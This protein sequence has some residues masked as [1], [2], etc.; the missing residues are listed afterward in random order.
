[1]TSIKRANNFIDPKDFDANKI[2]FSD[3]KSFGTN[4]KTAFII[5]NNDSNLGFKVPKMRMPFG[6]S[7]YVD[8][9]KP[10]KY[11]VDVSFDPDNNDKKMK[12][13]Y[14]ALQN[15]D[16]KILNE[17]KKNSLAWLRKKHITDDVLQSLFNPSI[18]KSKDK[19]TGEFDDKYPPMFKGKIQFKENQMKCSIFDH[20]R[21]KIDCN[22]LEKLEK[23]CYITG[24][25]KCTGLW[26][27]SGKFGCTWVFEQIKLD[28]PKPK[29][30]EYSIS[31]L[32]D[33]SD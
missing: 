20:N 16:N 17:A 1:M 11:A 12:T 10:T 15:F 4:S 2:T 23:G 19:A 14:D 30:K 13:F 26:F 9:D 3:V 18:K 27:S 22:A 31:D 28:K 24:V 8:E 5:Y 32:M 29:I 6:Y 21:Q 7:K 25:I 33:D